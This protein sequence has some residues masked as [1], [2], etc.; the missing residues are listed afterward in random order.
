MMVIFNIQVN[1]IKRIILSSL[2]ILLALVGTAQEFRTITEKELKE[3]IAGYWI[4]QLA[5]NYIGFPF[6][7]LYTEEPIPVFVDRYMNYKDI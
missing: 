6:E 1:Y 2:F 4:G 7:N 3:K 5:G